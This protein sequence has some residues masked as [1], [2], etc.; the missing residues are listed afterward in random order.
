MQILLYFVGRFDANYEVVAIIYSV[1][2]TDVEVEKEKVQAFYS[3]S[4]CMR[5]RS[6]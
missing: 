4:I 2:G 5:E 3:N 6:F 1:S